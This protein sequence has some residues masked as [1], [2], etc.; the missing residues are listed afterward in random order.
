LEFNTLVLRFEPGDKIYKTMLF[1][2]KATLEI[3]SWV[4]KII[5]SEDAFDCLVEFYAA[6]AGG[7]I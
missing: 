5:M 2:G 3:S 1:S 4:E 6:R 7:K